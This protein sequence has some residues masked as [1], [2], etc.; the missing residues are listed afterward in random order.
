MADLID[1]SFDQ[2]VSIFLLFRLPKNTRFFCLRSVNLLRKYSFVFDLPMS[3]LLSS[4]AYIASVQDW[5]V[6]QKA[7]AQHK[8]QYVW[9]RKL[10]MAFSRYILINTF[11]QL[12]PLDCR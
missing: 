6:L 7:M 10:Y 1:G 5:W 9:F 8:S 2:F 4:T 12:H 3:F 11:E